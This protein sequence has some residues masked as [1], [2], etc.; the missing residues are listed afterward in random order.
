MA[1][2]TSGAIS[3]ANI[4]TEFGGS[5][6]ISLSEYYGKD[7]VPSSGAISIGDFYGTSDSMTIA[8]LSTEVHHG[9]AQLSMMLPPVYIDSV[10]DIYV[11]EYSNGTSGSVGSHV[12]NVTT[13]TKT[14][15]GRTVSLYPLISF[16]SSGNLKAVGVQKWEHTEWNSYGN[17][18]GGY[19]KAT[20]NASAQTLTILRDPHIYETWAGGLTATGSATYTWNASSRSW[21]VTTV[22]TTTS[23]N[24]N[25]NPAW[26]ASPSAIT[27][28]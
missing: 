14:L 2:Q 4:Q 22:G 5:N 18:Q 26:P 9:G 25:P 19:F 21:S 6:P 16:D 23:W 15:N 20:T 8:P 13:S 3:L 12:W 1:L 24:N 11:H 7:T 10:G 17:V 28:T 27:F